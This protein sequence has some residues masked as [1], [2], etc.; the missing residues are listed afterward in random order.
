MSVYAELKRRNV[1]RVA[2]AYVLLGWALL[3]GADFLLDLI[4]APEWV[5]RALAVIVL[6]GL[7]F[8]LIF[9]WAFEL[10]PEGLKRESGLDRG[11]SATPGSHKKLNLVII[12]LLVL[13]IVMMAVER[14][15][16]APEREPDSEPATISMPAPKTVA[17]LPF[18][19]LSQ[20]QDQAWFADGLAEEII[21]ALVRV[22]DLSVAARTSS[23]AHKGT[24]RP[25]SE[26]GADLGV[27]HVLEG[28][29]R[30]SADRI[31]VTAQLIR[32]S[33]GFHV[34]SQTYDRDESDVIGIQED[35]AR[36]IAT[37]LETGTDPDALAQ[38]SQV[39]SDSV[40]AYQEY[41]RGLQ[42]RAR[43]NP[44]SSAQRL[45][46]TR[47]AYQHFE[48]ARS[49][50]PGFASAHVEAAQF[51]KTELTPNLLETGLS[52]LAPQAILAEYNERIG[53]AIET[54]Q[55]EA[56]RVRSLADRAEIDL[57]LRESRR[58]YERYLEM[59][60][61]D[62]AARTS[63]VRVLLMLSDYDAARR[64]MAHWKPTL[65]VDVYSAVNFT[66]FAWRA[67]D[68]AEAASGVLE[69]VNRWPSSSA[70]L[71][72]A[73]RG[74]LW[75]GRVAEAAELSARYEMLVPGGHPAMRAREACVNGDRSAAEQALESVDPEGNT[76][77][78][79]RW[80]IV[81]LLGSAE[82]ERALLE[83][84]V[85]DG[86]PYQL[87]TF[88]TYPQ[89]DVQPYPILTRILE[90]EGVQ[91]PPPVAPPFACPPAH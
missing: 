18:T 31:R 51:W 55:T 22:P 48:K 5:I 34:W 40:E 13:V 9:S 87:A 38:M 45:E 29:V 16:F 70:L 39:G 66:S 46:L 33:D 59:R 57:R 60:P 86:V 4:G 84:L 20:A 75:A 2:I 7:P 89:F 26:I 64:V 91:R 43:A 54:A 14:L 71:Y 49:I 50:D 53:K 90:R 65:L 77:A 72:Q 82:A 83:P 11:R 37:A 73:H 79:Q 12:G 35:L 32:V 74:L 58:L 44:D 8:V 62:G 42:A 17:V 30:S 85:E 76:R 56:D 27:A 68:A 15:A 67:G 47:L 10:T 24:N 21:N 3:Q 1:V 69:A 52:G 23:F 25:I 19:D 63:F 81:N 88:L 36:S 80:L 78:I 41:L 61:N 28:S 6:V